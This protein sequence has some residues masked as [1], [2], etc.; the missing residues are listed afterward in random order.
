MFWRQFLAAAVAGSIALAISPR[1]QPPASSREQPANDQER[2]DSAGNGFILTSSGYIVTNNRVVE[3]ATTLSVQI[4]GRE[5]PAAIRVVGRDVDNDLAIVK[6]DGPLG[7]PP[8]SFVDSKDLKVGQDLIVLG[9][10][11][12]L[13]PARTVRA[14]TVTLSSLSGPRNNLNVYQ[15]STAI[16]PGY[17]G[18]PVFNNDG[19]LVGVVVARFIVK[20]ALVANLLQRFPEGADVVRRETRLALPR[21]QQIETLSRWIVQILNSRPAITT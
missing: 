16:D 3:G 13:S 18:G 5:K 7:N 6:T 4:P 10:P 19:Q 14:S 11:L 17:D 9:Y 1:A 2:L 20:G 21:G 12:G 8:V 15:I